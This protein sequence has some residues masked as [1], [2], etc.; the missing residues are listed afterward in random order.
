MWDT[1]YYHVM[2]GIKVIRDTNFEMVADSVKPDA[3][4]R[5]VLPKAT[6]AEGVTYHVYHNRFGQIVLDPQ[7]SI[8]A[9]EAWLFNNPEALA[10][11]KQGL[12]ES[13]QGRT[14]SLGSFAKYAE[15]ES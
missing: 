2:M 3:K 13:A 7:V 5:I 9:Y 1:C 12:L 8:P 10:L 14:K 11:V 15:D 4:K 6:V